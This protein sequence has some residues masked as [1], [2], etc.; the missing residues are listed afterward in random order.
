MQMTGATPSMS[1]QPNRYTAQQIKDWCT[2]EEAAPGIWQP[3][4]P[5]GHNMF[6]ILHR[7]KLALDVLT[8]RAD[9]LYWNEVTNDNY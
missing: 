8:G 1:R 7:W 3:A 6:P 4:R 5:Y 9:A 2:S